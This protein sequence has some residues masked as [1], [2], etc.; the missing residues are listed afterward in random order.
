LDEADVAV[1]KQAVER[2]GG[3]ARV[4]GL[5]EALGPERDVLDGF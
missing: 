5:N 4:Y 2:A 1:E 3:P